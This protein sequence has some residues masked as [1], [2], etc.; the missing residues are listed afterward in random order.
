VGPPQRGAAER[1]A[2]AAAA[3]RLRAGYGDREG[4]VAQLRRIFPNAP[5]S[6]DRLGRLAVVKRGGQTGR[7]RHKWWP[8]IRRKA[9][10]ASQSADRL[11]KFGQTVVK[12]WSNCGQTTVKW[13]NGGEVVKLWWNGGQ[14]TV[15][16]SNGGQTVVKR[17]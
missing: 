12:R 15:K 11:V 9:P 1:E 2:A 13:S 4:T 7:D 14:T 6:G 10:S 17:R 3:K 8:N 16:W 5:L